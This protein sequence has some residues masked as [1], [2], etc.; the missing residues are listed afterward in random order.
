MEY[1]NFDLLLERAADGYTARVL[2]CPAGQA[3]A[4]FRNPFSDL[5]VENFFLRLGRPRRAVRRRESPEMEMVKQ[6]GGRLFDAVFRGDVRACLRSSLDEVR[7]EGK[8]LRIR[9]H[10]AAPELAD[11]PWEYLYNS[12]LNHF[13]SLSIGTPVVRYLELPLR[14]EPRVVRAAC[15]GAGIFLTAS[16]RGIDCGF[17]AL[18]ARGKPAEDV[19]AEAVESLLAHHRAAGAVDVHLA[20]QLLVVLALADGPSR[21]TVPQVTRHLTTNAWLVEQFGLAHV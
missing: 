4:D 17:A 11:W 5:E 19:A 3:S 16:Y 20:D 21:Y 7:R 12:A 1:L 6:F 13:L 8:G 9:L 14:I 10:L 18:G 15:A 2:A